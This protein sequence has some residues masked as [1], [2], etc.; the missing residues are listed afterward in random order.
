[1]ALS[2]DKKSLLFIK[3]EPASGSRGGGLG[4]ACLGGKGVRA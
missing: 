3:L 4:G 2:I 1:V